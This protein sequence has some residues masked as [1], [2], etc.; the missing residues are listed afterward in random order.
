MREGRI[1]RAIREHLAAHPDEAFTTEH[2]G[3]VCY[4]NAPSIERKHRVAVIRAADKVL[5]GDPDWRPDRSCRRGGTVILYNASSVMST[6]MAR[7]LR[8]GVYTIRERLHQDTRDYLE[9]HG[10]AWGTQHQ[11]EVAEDVAKHL[12]FCDAATLEEA[13]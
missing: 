3:V 6:A 8:H 11:E 9:P 10:W 4:P 1:E 5:T 12:A 13:E 2:L 7:V